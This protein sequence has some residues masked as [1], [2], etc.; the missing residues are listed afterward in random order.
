MPRKKIK[1]GKIPKSLICLPNFMKCQA[2]LM[3]T[4]CQTETEMSASQHKWKTRLYY[5]LIALPRSD[6]AEMLLHFMNIGSAIVMCD[7]PLGAWS[8]LNANI[9]TFSF[10]SPA[11]FQ[12]CS[13]IW[14]V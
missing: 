2:L 10:P 5:F 1:R 3:I 4:A 12:R 6:T 7:N 11:F 9:I 14:T 8:N 13:H